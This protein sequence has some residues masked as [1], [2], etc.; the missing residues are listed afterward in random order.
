MRELCPAC[1]GSDCGKCFS[2]NEYEIKRCATC[3][4]MFVE[5]LP[6][7]DELTAIYSSQGYYEL[8]LDSIQRITDENRRRMKV[9]Q[10]IKPNGKFLD[11]GCAHGLLLDH[12]LQNRYETFGVEPSLKNAQAAAR[13]NHIVFTGSLE[14]FVANNNDK[15][16]DVITCMDVIEH[17]SDPKAFL[18]LAASI[19]ANDGIMVVSTPNYS[20][21]I[22][23]LLGDQDPYM[24]PP[25]HLTFLTVA[26]MIHLASRCG[27][28]I[29]RSRTFGRPIPAEV[30][31]SIKRYIPGSLRFLR[32]VMQPA[33]YFSFWLL[34]LMKLG[35]EQEVY[36]R[37]SGMP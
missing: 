19:L 25:E 17:I 2:V 34:N 13:N 37:R 11:I 1:D 16:F 7:S 27:L 18:S 3:G 15:T 35:L 29:M 32:P 9:I 4:T 10:S 33:I 30:D 6:S 36:L 24:T 5:N 28:K 23:K 21:V 14:E 22:A 31:R 12:A 20:G 8:P 26:G